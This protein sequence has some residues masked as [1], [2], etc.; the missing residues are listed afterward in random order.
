MKSFF[1][2]I[3]CSAV[4]LLLIS[5][6][7]D[8]NKTDTK[9]EQHPDSA[10]AKLTDAEKRMP[11]HAIEGLEIAEG[12]NIS[13]FASEPMIGNP[14]NIDVDA[15]GR[16]WVCEALNYRP[17]LNPNNPQRDAGDRILILEDSDGDGKADTAKVFYQGN[18]VNAALGIAVLGNK[19]IVSCSPN[20]FLFSDSDGYDNP[21]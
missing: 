11:E 7:T 18:D 6:N 12:L 19:V 8:N 3:A 20:V 17:K 15:K 13:L 5:C 1:F 4:I 16:V 21:D 9:R 2:P 10:Y 14:T